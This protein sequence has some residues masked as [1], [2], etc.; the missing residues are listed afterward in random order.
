LREDFL[1]RA[2]TDAAMLAACRG[3]RSADAMS[4]TA[5]EHARVIAHGLA[6]NAGMAGFHRV[7]TRAARLEDA[8]EA[9]PVGTITSDMVA[10]AIE[11]LIREIRRIAPTS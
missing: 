9:E 2:R 1:L 6:E 7:G 10:R 11:G 4:P 8:L 3:E 5:V